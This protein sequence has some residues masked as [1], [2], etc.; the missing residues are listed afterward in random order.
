MNKEKTYSTTGE[1]VTLDEAAKCSIY[2]SRQIQK[3]AETGIQRIRTKKTEDGKHLLYNKIDILQYAA[4]H[5]RETILDT[6]WDEINHIEGECF[7]PLFGYD[8][9]YF[10]SNKLRVINCSNGQILTPQPHKDNKGN[11]TGYKQV[12]LRKHGENKP[13]KLHRLVGK[14]QCPNVLGKDIFHH[15]KI[16]F[17]SDDKA[18]N[19]LPVWKS[20]HDELHK[21][22][23]EKKTA[24]Y[25][26][27]IKYI[28]KENK[29]LYKI[30]H[31]DYASN[32]HYNYFMFVT[33]GGY[34][35][36]KADKELPLNSIVR[37]SAEVKETKK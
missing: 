3:L 6:V 35:A 9:K 19:L 24:E 2:S 28:K 12:T 7:Y 20:Q 13:E 30:P 26:E 32:E 25:K 36:Y 14:T 37:E 21:L 29:Q 1:W 22:L 27:M 8:C 10:V 4:S 15:I 33:Y 17:P 31:L 11:E 34:L 23:R 5:P 16:C 18:S